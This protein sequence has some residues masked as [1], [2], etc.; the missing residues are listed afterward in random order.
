MCEWFQQYDKHRSE[1]RDSNAAVTES[2]PLLE[3]TEGDQHHTKGHRRADEQHPVQTT[4]DH[5]RR[6]VLALDT[7]QETAKN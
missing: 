2:H 4:Y 6:V 1:R 3:R 7:A 5:C